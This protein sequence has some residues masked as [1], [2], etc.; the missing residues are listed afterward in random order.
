MAGWGCGGVGGRV[1]GFAPPPPF[2]RSP[3]PSASRTGRIGGG[4]RASPS[5]SRTGRIGRR[6]SRPPRARSAWGGGRHDVRW[7]GFRRWDTPPP[8]FARFP[9][10]CC[11]WGG[12]GGGGRLLGAGRHGVSPASGRSCPRHDLQDAG[13]PAPE[14]RQSCRSPLLAQAG[15]PSVSLLA[16]P[17]LP[18]NASLRS[19]PQAAIS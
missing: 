19:G 3:S 18:C 6:L 12:T 14:A 5:A 11:T 16:A 8:C 1:W 4:L 15:R 2:G 13:H 17:R 10:P 7:R 9:S